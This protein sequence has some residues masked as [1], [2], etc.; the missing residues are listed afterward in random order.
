MKKQSN[1]DSQDV[2]RAVAALKEDL[3]ALLEE[4]VAINSYSQNAEGVVRVAHLLRQALPSPLAL[5]SAKYSNEGTL[6]ICGH[7]PI[8][9]SPLLLVGH[10]DTVFP[11]DTFDSGVDAEGAYLLGPGVADMK[12]GLVVMVGAL[13]TLDCL[14]ALFGI[15]LRK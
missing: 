1:L 15:P 14:N 5:V 8:G 3:L 7:G 9:V 2:K 6:W 4:M 11:P 10:L 13:W 12:G